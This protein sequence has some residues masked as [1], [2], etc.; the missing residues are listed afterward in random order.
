MRAVVVGAGIGGLT[1][2]IALKQRGWQVRLLER[3]DRLEPIGA[4]IVLAPNAV[5]CLDS[6]GLGDA[7]R[8]RGHQPLEG[9]LLEA[10]G[11]V[12]QRLPKVRGA[13]GVP[14]ITLHRAEL[15]EV[16]RDALGRD[17][18]ELGQDVPSDA[19]LE[20]DLIVGADGIRSVV[21]NRVAP[22]HP[23]PQYAGFVAWRAVLDAVATP[24]PVESWGG[25]KIFG[26]VP[27]AKNRTYLYATAR[28]ERERADLGVLGVADR[29]R[30]AFEGWHP[31][32]S[33]LLSTLR[34][35]QVLAHPVYWNAHPLPRY[36]A[37]RVAL[38]GDAAHAMTPNLGQGA[39]QAIEDAVVLASTVSIDSLERSL[40]G[41]SAARVHRTQAISRQSYRLGRLAHV[42]GRVPLALRS[43]ALRTLAAVAPTAAA[44][45]S[46]GIIDW[47]PPRGVLPVE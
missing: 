31:P 15:V 3:A 5:R 18:L 2:A 11:R 29:L 33:E 38:V 44:R 10:S 19:Q 25:G 12:I 43:G 47:I 7:L 16:L 46:A 20:S 28:V 42:S 6:L 30:A 22:E 9:Q 36:H 4:G 13:D 17:V 27:L 26:Y 24:D 39:C 45:G 1:A 35:E 8:A 32:V 21:R 40:A 14:A 41:Y 23:Q 37:G 34:D